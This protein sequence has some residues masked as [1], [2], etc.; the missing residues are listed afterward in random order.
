VYAQSALNTDTA[1]AGT[2]TDRAFDD[3]DARIDPSSWI[4]AGSINWIPD[5]S[6]EMLVS[7]RFA[8][9]LDS[10]SNRLLARLYDVTGATALDH[11][12]Q[13]CNNGQWSPQ[14]DWC[15]SAVASNTY[16]LQDA[17]TGAGTRTNDART[18][19]KFLL[20]APA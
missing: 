9:S 16:K 5:A 15:F 20:M 17:S 19:V 7:F 14:F 8:N 2:Y 1:G 10:G 12:F 3:T 13:N 6:G 18:C 4:Q 11:G